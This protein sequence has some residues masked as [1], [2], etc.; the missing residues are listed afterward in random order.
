MNANPQSA[1]AIAATSNSAW[2]RNTE[3]LLT[4]DSLTAL[5]HNEIPAIRIRAFASN[6]ECV[7]FC[8]AVRAAPISYYSVMPPVGY[9]GMAQYEYRWNQPKEKYF[10]DVPAA[11]AL[12]RQVTSNSFDPVERLIRLLQTH[13][14]NRIC[15]A[16]EPGLGPYYAG[17]V[18]IA[19]GGIRLHADYA[20]FNSP[21]YTIGAIDAQLGWNFFAEQPSG[22]GNTT[23]HNKPW[24]PA[25]NGNEIPASYDLPRELVAGAASHSYAPTAGDVVIF[26]T[27]N[28]HEVAGGESEASG[29][30]VS[31]GSFIGRLPDGSFGLWS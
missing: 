26:N 17:I 13:C 9:I 25:L 28:P 15:V 1:G 11:N 21:D 2:A 14:D 23:V 6:A 12:L 27:R 10:L 31:I 4:R 18:R 3:E 16:Q 5:L 20:P 29:D 30:R 19:S 24:T 22:G 8:N 7:A